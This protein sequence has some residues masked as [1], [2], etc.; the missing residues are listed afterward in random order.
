MHHLHSAWLQYP[1]IFIHLFSILLV[2]SFC[3]FL[4][5]EPSHFLRPAT[6][7]LNFSCPSPSSLFCFFVY[8]FYFIGFI[9]S[10]PCRALCEALLFLVIEV[11]CSSRSLSLLLSLP[12]EVFFHI[13]WHFNPFTPSLA[14]YLFSRC[15]SWLC[16]PLCSSRSSSRS[17]SSS[18][19]CSSHRSS[20][21]LFLPLPSRCFCSSSPPCL[22]EPHL[23]LFLFSYPLPLLP[24]SYLYLFVFTQLFF[25]DYTSKILQ[26]R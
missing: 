9:I 21:F 20:F 23:I 2:V 6:S 5:L 1:P 8:F 7:P 13:P 16:C 12:F 17:S 18:P 22:F 4:L 3:I 24:L 19:Y 11:F 14:C 26:I 10:F 15:V 25:F